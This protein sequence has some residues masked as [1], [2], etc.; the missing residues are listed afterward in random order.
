MAMNDF[1]TDPSRQNRFLADNMGMA[2][3]TDTWGSCGLPQYSPLSFGCQGPS[4]TSDSIRR[5]RELMKWN[6]VRKAWDNTNT[7]DSFDFPQ[8]TTPRYAGFPSFGFESS[9]IQPSPNSDPFYAS[10][11]T[12]DQL[13][14]SGLQRRY[15]YQ[16]PNLND[17][18]N[19]ALYQQTPIARP[20]QHSLSSFADFSESS[21]SPF[22]LVSSSS[23][24]SSATSSRRPS[25]STTATSISASLYSSPPGSTNGSKCKKAPHKHCTWCGHTGHQKQN[26]RDLTAAFRDG[27]VHARKGKICLGR[28]GEGGEPIPYPHGEKTLRDWVW[29][30]RGLPI[31]DDYNP[32]I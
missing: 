9:P 27:I 22:S 17:P 15:T 8:A 16:I 31:Q 13:A 11:S 1:V 4:A 32:Y 24:N 29:K 2:S 25:S 3:P 28:S 6:N 5:E 23:T 21:A 18:F 10:R 14:P 30:R 19:S 26:C 12:A 20:K 7:Q